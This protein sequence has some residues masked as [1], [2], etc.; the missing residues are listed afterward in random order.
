M[1]EKTRK[2]F[3]ASIFWL[4]VIFFV[5]IVF[6]LRAISSISIGL[7]LILGIAQKKI[8]G[9]S[10]FIK[11]PLNFFVLGCVLLYLINC[12]SLLYTQNT[13]EG[14]KHLQRTSALIFVP[15]AM[16]ASQ[17]FLNRKIFGKL[18]TWLAVIIA[19]AGAY[20]IA[21]ALYRYNTGAQSMV[22]F[23]FDL[24]KPLSQHAIQLSILVFISLIFLF[25]SINDPANA[26]KS[27]VL[28]VLIAFLTVFLFL[29]S[30]KLILVFYVGYLFYFIIRKMRF[31]NLKPW[32]RY[33]MVSGSL[34]LLAIIFTTKNP[35][36]N[37]FRDIVLGDANFFRQKTFS[38]SDYFNG[39]QFRLLQWRFVSEIM[40]ETNRWAWGLSPGDAQ[41]YLDQ[42][43]VSANMYTGRP[44]TPKRGFLGY[45][46]HNEFLQVFL[47][48][49]IPGLILFLFTCYGLVRMA[50]QKKNP[51][52]NIILLLLLVYCF[53]DAIL[54]TQYGLIIF[55]FF[56]PF[57][58]LGKKLP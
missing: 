23:Y 57:I 58:Y 22:F 38:Q 13:Q 52:L 34:L 27:G 45:H 42:K 54:E 55:T 2:Y 3:S 46:T 33:A 17:H 41:S 14:L 8:E 48:N 39:L 25:E 32:L 37:R 1:P 19:I 30:S 31:G 15:L 4:Y 12:F 20:C 24:V 56:P 43:Y 6:S 9:K 7:I 29:L 36:N 49:G 16:Y 35:L 50:R 47:Q 18:M 28:I 53:T 40:S 5:S 11:N 44:G 10:F 51:M 21:I 26:S